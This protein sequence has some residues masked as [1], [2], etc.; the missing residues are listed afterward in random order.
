MAKYIY[1]KKGQSLLSPFIHKLV[2]SPLTEAVPWSVPANIVTIVANLFLYMALYFTLD[3]NM[4]GRGNFLM[5]PLMLFLY[6]TGKKLD[7]AQAR[8]TYT[9]TPLGEF[10]SHFLNTFEN[11]ILLYILFT[12]F[13]VD[14][15]LLF[16]TTLLF[17]YLSEMAMFYEQFKTGWLVFDRIYSLEKIFLSIVLILV[18]YIEDIYQFLIVELFSALSLSELFFALLALLALVTFIKTIFRITNLTYGFWLFVILLVIV[19]FFSAF[20]YSPLGVVIIVTLYSCLYIGKLIRAHL[21]DSVERSP[22][23]FTPLFLLIVF[24]TGDFFD[25]NTIYIITIYLLA[26]IVLLVIQT[27]KALKHHWLWVNPARSK[28]KRR[29]AK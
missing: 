28:R 26:N 22:G 17:G 27:S 16:V 1:Q 9:E 24:F 6:V 5:I 8:K 23:I 3:Q 2:I 15:I 25:V 4:L 19:G 7:G 11:G 21:V 18:S 12:V 14:H 29:S 10:L 20:L 13:Q